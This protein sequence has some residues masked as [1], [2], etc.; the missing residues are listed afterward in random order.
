MNYKQQQNTVDDRKNLIGTKE[1]AR[2]GGLARLGTK[3]R[4]RLSP[5]KKHGKHTEQKM[6]DSLFAL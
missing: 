1:F 6:V 2:S 4:G 5:K 3:N